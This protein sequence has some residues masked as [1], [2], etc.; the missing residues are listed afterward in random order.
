M[1]TKAMAI[2]VCGWM[3]MLVSGY[4]ILTHRQPNEASFNLRCEYLTST[5]LV[6]ADYLFT[7]KQSIGKRCPVFKKNRGNSEG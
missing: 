1:L 2:L 3:T 5:G 7:D 6:N 4:G